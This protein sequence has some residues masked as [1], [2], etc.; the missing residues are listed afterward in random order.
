MKPFYLTTTLP[1]VNAEPHIGFALEMIQAD[2]IAR[3]ERLLGREVVFSTG[4]DEHGQ[5][6]YQKAVDAGL[7]PQEYCDL[8]AAKFDGLKMAL[9]LSYTHFIRTTDQKHEKAAQEIWN[10]CKASGDIYKKKYKGLYCVGDEMFLREQDL[11]DGKCPN[12]PTMEPITIEEENYFFAF[13][14]YKDQLLEYLKKEHVIVPDWR[15]AEAVAFI[16][17]G[18]QDF[19][20]SRTKERMPWGIPVPDDDTQVMYVWFDALTNYISTLGWPDETKDG[21]FDT[22]WNNGESVQ[23]AGKDQIRFQSLMWQAMLMSAGIKNTDYIFY[24]GFISSEGKKMSKSIGNVV[25]PY[26]TVAEFGS[27]AVRFYL[28]GALPAY[29]DGDFSKERF[30]TF[31]T[32]H[33]VNGIGNLVSRVLSM[34]EKYTD[35]LVPTPTST[36][37]FN[38]AEYWKRYDAAEDAYKFD[39]MVK[40]LND[41]VAAVDGY[42]SDAKPWEKAKAGESIDEILYV[43]VEAVRHIGLMMLPLM[44]ERAEEL[45]ANKLLINVEALPPLHQINSWGGLQEGARTEKGIALFP[46]LE[47]RNKQEELAKTGD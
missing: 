21:E 27:A 26:E 14:K 24:H 3:Y 36:D 13:S 43:T 30:E 4:T 33:L 23:V 32:A 11:V 41:L 46:R 35:K 1:Y 38:V 29:S 25:D 17:D 18:L 5:K 12:H 40:V 28:L 2:A 19:S 15:L 9:N 37:P 42:I 45:L 44:P 8:Y 39:E 31:Y 10:R 6:I 47:D 22:F 34:L 16:E 7:D 20:I